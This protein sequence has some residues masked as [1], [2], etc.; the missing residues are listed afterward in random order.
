L[1]RISP[2]QGKRNIKYS[3]ADL[4]L[5]GNSPSNSSTK[6]N[7]DK[8]T[9]KT[10][11]LFEDILGKKQINLQELKSHAWNGIPFGKSFVYSERNTF[12]TRRNLESLARILSDQLRPPR[13]NS[14]EQA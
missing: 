14:Y 2:N 13:E 9:L 3:A 11:K 4:V 12:D 10:I 5:E 8:K 6:S 7:E 1:A